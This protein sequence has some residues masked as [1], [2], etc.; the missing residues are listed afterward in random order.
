MPISGHDYTSTERRERVVN[1]VPGTHNHKDLKALLVRRL[2][3][4]AGVSLRSVNPS[5]IGSLRHSKRNGR[6]VLCQQHVCEHSMFR[7]TR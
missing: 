3:T 7:N 2:G 1:V 5:V 6:D 4:L